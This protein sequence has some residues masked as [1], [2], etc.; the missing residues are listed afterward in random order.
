MSDTPETDF[1]WRRVRVASEMLA[2]WFSGDMNIQA[3][4]PNNVPFD[5]QVLGL[6]LVHSRGV[7]EFVIWS[8][9]FDPLPNEDGRLL[10]EIPFAEFEYSI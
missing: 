6:T 7:W 3:A 2:G 5:I 9:T 4:V 1:R 10:G 8:A